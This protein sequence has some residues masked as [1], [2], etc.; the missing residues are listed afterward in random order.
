MEEVKVRPSFHSFGPSA[1][2]SLCTCDNHCKAGLPDHSQPATRPNTARCYFCVAH[3]L[4][5]VFMSLNGWKIK[6]WAFLDMKNYV[7][8]R[9]QSF[10]IKLYWSTTMPIHLCIVYGAFEL[11]HLMGF[12]FTETLRLAKPNIVTVCP[13]TGKVHRLLFLG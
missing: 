12:I 1:Q 7:K 5:M 3:K 8:F 2:A 9:Y 13:F 10:Y 11:R 4:K 6:R